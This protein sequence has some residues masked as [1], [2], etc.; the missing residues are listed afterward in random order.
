M[1]D[2]NFRI[3][4]P[5]LYLSHFL[6]SSQH[7][8]FLI[9]IFNDPVFV[10]RNGES[11]VKDETK[12]LETITAF[13]ERLEKYGYGHYIASLKP[14][15]GASLTDSKPIGI[16]TLMKGD[17]LVPDVGFAFVEKESGKGYATEAGKAIIEYAKRELGISEV[18]GFCSVNNAASK[19][20]LAKVGLEERAIMKI[21]AFGKD[22]ESAVYVTPGMGPLKDYKVIEPTE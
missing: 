19:R 3:E 22:N 9:E 5:R 4:T 20:V 10:S 13:Q 21:A 18:L 2:P 7:A 1:S 15:A 12:A 11:D 14:L 16:V 8:S 17:M 6:S